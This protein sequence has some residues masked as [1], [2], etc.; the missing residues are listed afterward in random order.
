MTKIITPGNSV[1][2]MKIGVH[3]Q[4]PLEKIVERKLK[5]IDEAGMAFWG[6]GGNTCH[7]TTMVQPFAHAQAGKGNPIHLVMQKMESNHVA[8]PI[9]ADEYSIDGR[10]WIA[11]PKGVNVLGSRYALIIEDLEE[12][13]LTLP[14][15]R[16]TVALGPSRGRVG[17]GYVSGR[18]DKACLELG[19][20][21]DVPVPADEGTKI[22][23]VARLKDPYAVFLRN[24]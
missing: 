9:P 1:L 4:E 5:E 19:D 6:Y 21:V 14:L 20:G 15:A 11:V 8:D 10:T 17:L 7:P 22:G 23:L 24:R 12:A 3:A 13:D 16:T 2:F 18:V